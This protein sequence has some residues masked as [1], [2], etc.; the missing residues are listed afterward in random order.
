[1]QG[2]PQIFNFIKVKTF[3]MF[4]HI[5]VDIDTFFYHYTHTI[6]QMEEHK[7]ELCLLITTRSNHDLNRTFDLE[8]KRSSSKESEH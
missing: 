7:S 5:P 8:K 4:S 1:M 3:K 2:I 6:A